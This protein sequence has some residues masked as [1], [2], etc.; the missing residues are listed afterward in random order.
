MRD[1]YQHCATDLLWLGDD[2][3]IIEEGAA[4]MEDIDSISNLDDEFL[5]IRISDHWATGVNSEEV[6]KGTQQS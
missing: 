5:Q 1:I 4:A 2:A 6:E 3:P